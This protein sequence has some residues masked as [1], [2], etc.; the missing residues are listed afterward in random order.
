[1][2]IYWLAVALIPVAYA[3]TSNKCADLTKF[4]IPGVAM[5]ITKAEKYSRF[6]ARNHLS[7]SGALPG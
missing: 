4:K 3:Q 5:V 2:R 6:G 7:C 1:M